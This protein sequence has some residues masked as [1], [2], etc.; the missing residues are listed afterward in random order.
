VTGDGPSA[1]A[2][3]LIGSHARD[4]RA[5]WGPG[6]SSCVNVPYQ[7]G[8]YA[9]VSGRTTRAYLSATYGEWNHWGCFNN[10]QNY[11]GV[12]PALMTTAPRWESLAWPR[13]ITS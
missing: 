12:F 11:R 7:Y 10:P 13:P 5:G 9:G 4:G 6:R 8:S 1:T 2:N 3:T